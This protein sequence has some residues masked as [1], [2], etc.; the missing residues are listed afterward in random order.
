MNNIFNSFVLTT[1]AGL[2]TVLGFFIIFVKGERHKIISFFLSFASGVMFIISIIDLIPSSL[3]YFNNYYLFYRLLLISIFII[4]GIIISNFINHL[5]S[6]YE[7]NNLTKLGILSFLSIILHNV[8]EGII[9]FM[10]FQID[11]NLGISMAIAISLHNIPEGI[12]IAVPLYYANHPKWKIFLVVL[13]AGLSELLGALLTYL[14]LMNFISDFFM[15]LMLSL[16]AGIMFSISIFSLLK[17]GVSYH[18]KVSVIGF[19]FGI[20]IM[21]FSSMYI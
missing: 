2:S 8:P 20:L 10:S 3:N 1:L 16:T 13:V 17:E 19:I 11:L 4:V 21:I 15:G 9:T 18:K 7:N 12:S 14:F 5:I 6:R